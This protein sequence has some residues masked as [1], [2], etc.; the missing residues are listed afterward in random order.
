MIVDLNSVQSDPFSEKNF[1]VCI[2]GAGFAGIT[3]ALNLPRN[4]K[5]LLLEGGGFKASAE[6]QSV[7]EGVS[8]GQTFIAT[9]SSRLRYFGGTSGSWGGWCRPLDE[10]DFEPKSYVPYS[11]WPIRIDDL[12]PYLDKAEAM[13]ELPE[14]GSWS[15]SQSYFEEQIHE[16][17]DFKSGTYKFSPPT[18]FGQKYRQEIE[19]R[20]NLFCYLN[21]NVTDLLLTKDL[22]RLDH[23]KVHDYS[24]RV[25]EVSA[26][27]FVLATGGL[28]NPRILLNS[29][30]QIPAGVGNQ[31]GLVGKFF[32]EHPHAQIA[33]VLL[34]DRTKTHIGQYPFGD[35]FKSRLKALVCNSEWALRSVNYV[36]RSWVGCMSPRRHFFSPTKAFMER[37]QILNFSLRLR[38]RSPGH[39]L[40]TDGSLNIE[41]ETAPDPLNTVTLG[42]DEDMFGMRRIEVNWRLSEIDLHTMRR[43]A[44]RFGEAFA[45][46]GLGRVRIADWPN[47]DST[48]DAARAGSHHMCTTRMAESPA[49]GVVDENQKV[50]GTDNL[51]IAGSSVWSTAGYANPTLAIIQMTLRLA[52][53]IALRLK[54]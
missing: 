41:S 40:P 50:F 26:Q 34:E 52:D 43:A 29:N 33:E 38:L 42:H 37:E 27:I 20:S 4:L 11:G 51:Y 19:G 39:G 47:S 14:E 5:V 22:S 2:C 36:R 49:N 54:S 7:Y 3:M 12:N 8:K 46:L 53:H 35:S 32:T 10:Y 9:G 23:V 6:S 48:E 16:T 30:K 17:A 31:N 44:I 28:E 21:A 15:E 45:D 1:D 24:G 25:F 13:V 18:R